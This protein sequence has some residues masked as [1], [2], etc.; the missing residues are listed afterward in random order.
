MHLGLDRIMNVKQL[1]MKDALQTD[2]VYSGVYAY[3][4]E[5]TVFVSSML[6]C[7]YVSTYRTGKGSKNNA[8]HKNRVSMKGD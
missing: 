4:H 8:F 7:T 6:G 2:T 3:R 5:S 1:T